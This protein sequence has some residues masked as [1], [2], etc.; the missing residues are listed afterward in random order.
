MPSMLTPSSVISNYPDLPTYLDFPPTL[1]LL[2][3]PIIPATSAPPPL[4]PGSPSAHPQPTICAVRSPRVCLSPSASW[5]GDPSSSP[6]ASESWTPPR[7]LAPSSPPSPIGPPAPSGSFVPPAPPWS[8]VIPPSP[9]DSTP[10]AVPRCSAPPA[11][12]SGSA[13]YLRTSASVARALG[14]TLALW[15]LGFARTHLRSGSGSSS[16]CCAAVGFCTDQ[17]RINGGNSQRSLA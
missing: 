1:P 4:H 15:I 5:L 13:A 9:Q 7:L 12:R 11:P 6:P 2:P 14:S 10:P 16:T 8:V 3:P 17:L